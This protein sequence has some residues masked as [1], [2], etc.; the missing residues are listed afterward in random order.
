M[1]LGNRLSEPTNLHWHGLTAPAAMDG[2]PTD[3]VAPGASRDFAVPILEQAGTYWY[4]PHPDSHTARQ[5][6]LG[7]AG[8]LI[9]EDPAEAFSACPLATEMC[10]SCCR[11]GAR[12]QGGR[13]YA[14]TI[15]TSWRATSETSPS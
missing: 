6:Y 10:P 3:L 5:V 4:H 7:M 14:P 11:I 8:F 13:S 15:W 1:R 9:V 12:R 2:F